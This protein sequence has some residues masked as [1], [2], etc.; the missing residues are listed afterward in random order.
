LVVLLSK[1][2]E[3]SLSVRGIELAGMFYLSDEL[4]ALRAELAANNLSADRLSVRYNPWD[5]GWVWVLNPVTRIHLQVPAVDPA[6]RGLTSYQWR[7]LRRAV[8]D[9]FDA[10]DHVLSLA[11]ARN[12]IRDV[13]DGAVQKPS[14]RRRVRAAR[15]S[16]D[17]QG[18]SGAA[19]PDSGSSPSEEGE[20]NPVPA[21]ESKSPNSPQSEPNSP[22]I[23]P[24]VLDVDD[25]DVSC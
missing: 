23:E 18:I 13:V 4:A 10:P 3:R 22:P 2:T 20:T 25:W 1:S 5:L 11:A 9:R 8:R 15:Y 17:F 21:T 12:A 6:L 14:R 7:V 24:P 19:L 16:G